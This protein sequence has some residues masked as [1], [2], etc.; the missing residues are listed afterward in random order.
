VNHIK[1]LRVSRHNNQQT[2]IHKSPERGEGRQYLFV[3]TGMGARSNQDR[4]L[5]RGEVLAQIGRQRTH[6]P[7]QLQIELDATHHVKGRYRQTQG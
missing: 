7:V 4:P 5:I 2:V 3:L 6:S 1:T